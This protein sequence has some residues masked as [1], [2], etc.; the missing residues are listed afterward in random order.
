MNRSPKNHGPDRPVLIAAAGA[1]DGAGLDAAPG[2]VLATVDGAGLTIHASG[3]SSE[4]ERH[5][6]A[7]GAR[8]VDLPSHVLIPGLVNAH[9]HLD[10]THVGPRPYLREGGFRGWLEMVLKVRLPDEASIRASVR[11]GIRRSLGGGVVAVGDIAGV[12]R[13]EPTHEL[14]AS[15]LVGDSFHEFFGVGDRQEPTAARIGAT[16][17]SQDLTE[18][19]VRLGLTPHAPYT[20]G[21]RLYDYSQREGERLGVP[22]ATHLAEGMDEREFVAK[23]QGLFRELLE[24]LGVWDD[25]AADDVGRGRTPIHHLEPSLIRRPMLLAHVNDCPDEDIERLAATRASVAYCPRCSDYFL[26]HE[27]FGLHRYREMLEAGINVCLGTDSVINLPVEQA[28]RISTLDDARFLYSRDGTDP[29]LLLKLATMHGARA[30]GLNPAMFTLAPGRVAAIVA[31]DVEGV[32]GTPIER[33]MRSRLGATLVAIGKP[34]HA[35]F[36]GPAAA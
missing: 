1:V 19:G 31:V 26:R 36:L 30:L 27:E 32:D 24:R 22:V 29:A 14:R 7:E 33:V 25:S 6:L 5:P 13:L 10:L 18:N 34:G 4:V 21:P 11:D 8:R 16:L 12:E 9:S 15:P 17:G 35:G 2:A 3:P 23:G 20:V 28:D